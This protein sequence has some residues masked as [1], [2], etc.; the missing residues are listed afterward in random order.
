MQFYI[1]F[2]AAELKY[3]ENLNDFSQFS[4]EIGAIV[5]CIGLFSQLRKSP[6]NRRK[7]PVILKIWRL[8]PQHDLPNGLDVWIILNLVISRNQLHITATSDRDNNPIS[9]IFMKLPR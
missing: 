5:L 1:I 2:P 7:R 4:D 3:P 9:W 6:L 8:K